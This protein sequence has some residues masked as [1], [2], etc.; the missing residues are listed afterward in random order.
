M[1]RKRYVIGVDV[2]TGSAR[3]AL[4]DLDGRMLSVA[5][6]DTA[7]FREAGAVF[8]QSSTEIGSG[9]HLF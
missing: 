6:R 9:R 7:L 3:A 2:G 1:T 8:E 5:E 4:F